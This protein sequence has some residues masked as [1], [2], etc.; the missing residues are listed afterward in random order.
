MNH[1][2]IDLE[3]YSKVD[4]KECGLRRYSRDSTSKILMANYAFD[5]GPVN[6]IEMHRRS[7]P[8][9]LIEA[10]R[11]PQVK[12]IAHNAQFEIEMIE[13]VWGIPL[14]R[15]QWWCTMVMALSL[16]LPAQLGQLAKDALKLPPRYQ[17]DKRGDALMKMFSFPNS[18]ATPDT[19]PKEWEEYCQYGSQ[20]V[21]TEQK[22][23]K[24]LRAYIPN[25]DALFREWVLD[26]KINAAGLPVDTLFIE[27]AQAIAER[28]K[29]EFAEKMYEATWLLNP[30]ST[31]QLLPWLRDRGYPF[32]ELRKN[33]VEIALREHGDQIDGEA[34]SVLKMRL[35][36]NKTSTSKFAAIKRSSYKGRLCNTFQFMGAAATGRYAGRILG[37]NMPR[38]WKGC[39]A[40]LEAVRNMIAEDD[41]DGLVDFFGQP[42]ECVV[43]SIRSSI[44]APRGKKLV[45]ADLSSIELVVIAWL[46]N[47]KFWL[48]VVH[49]GKDAY[50]AFAEQWLKVPYEEVEKWQRSLCKPPALGCG[51]RMGPG[52]EVLNTKTK[53]YEKTG[54]WG[55]A[56]NMAVE[57]SKE[58]CKEAVK[59]YRA[60]SP[61]V[62]QSWYDLQ[63]AAMECVMTKEPQR[64]GM[65]YFDYKRPFLRMR[66]PSG[67][68]IH[69]CAPRIEMVEIEYENEDGEI[70]KEK[71]K[72]L[73]Y[74]RLSQTS[75][76][77]VRRANHGGRFIEQAVQGIARDILQVGLTAADKAGFEVVGHY[78][79]EILTLVDR[80]GPL[81]LEELIDCMTTMPGWAKTMMVGAAGYE[82]LFYKKD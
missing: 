53:D 9:A 27:S 25:P 32:S 74:E 63:S 8:K 76:K 30:N 82:S 52:R 33:R 41:Y 80:D 54:L 67:R 26:Q 11:D 37:Q 21:V 35:Q 75:K 49:S 17:K 79:D 22:V 58:Q 7:L 64:V 60:L 29:K 69:Y 34:K 14:D 59:I 20:D 1:L 73:T 23:Y 10:F 56:A 13:N 31:Q 16:G 72:G 12:K 68:Y 51:Y 78:H 3:T 4:L 50:K 71:K 44:A 57:M 42:L 46:T 48:D 61:E 81:G 55:Y 5:D 40:H 62:V 6:L 47:C 18:K 28:A 77:W 2:H 43:S 36:S 38:P 15:S 65:L 70:V 24:I 19:H 66:L 39:E 45:V